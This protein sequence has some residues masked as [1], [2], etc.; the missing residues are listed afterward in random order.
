MQDVFFFSLDFM[1]NTPNIFIISGPA[2]SGK[3]TIIEHLKRILPIERII[4]TTT[5]APR[6]GETEGNPYYFISSEAF[7]EAIRKESFAEYSTNENHTLYG[8]SN[9]ELRR[10]LTKKNCV[11][12]WQ[13]DW[14]GVESAKK[15]FPNIIAIFISTPLAIMEERLRSR[16]TT[17]NEIYFSERKAYT[18]E[19][20]KHTSLYDYV[21]KNEQGKLEEAVEAVKDIILRHS[22]LSSI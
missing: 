10:V 18:K 5:R 15:L 9:K 1:N 2:G 16:D 6:S 14:K 8:V 3:D 21:V 7:Q 12:I 4:T 22:E 11:G 20:L 19:W 17:Q 13:I